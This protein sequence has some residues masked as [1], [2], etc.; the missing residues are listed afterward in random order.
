MTYYNFSESLLNRSEV[1]ST[2]D[3]LVD[4]INIVMDASSNLIQY[5][6]TV[7]EASAIR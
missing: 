3:T 1:E 7:I 6:Q 2:H 5:T 4:L